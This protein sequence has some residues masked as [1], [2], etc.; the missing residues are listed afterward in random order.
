P[1]LQGEVIEDFYRIRERGRRAVLTRNRMKREKRVEERDVFE[2]EHGWEIAISPSF[3]RQARRFSDW[4]KKISQIDRDKTIPG[5]EKAEI[6]KEIMRRMIELAK[7]KVDA[8]NELRTE[9]QGLLNQ[10]ARHGRTREGNGRGS[11]KGERSG[12]I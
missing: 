10:G 7:E 2:R 8:A 6:R 4:R 12:T 3:E 1:S 11:A 5:S 9:I